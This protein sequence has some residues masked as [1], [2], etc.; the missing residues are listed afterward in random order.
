MAGPFVAMISVRN[1][2]SPLLVALRFISDPRSFLGG[3]LGGGAFL[4]NHIILKGEHLRRIKMAQL[5]KSTKYF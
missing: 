3:L 2:L 1:T 5:L 4:I